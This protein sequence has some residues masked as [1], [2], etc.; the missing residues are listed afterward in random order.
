[1]LAEALGTFIL[2]LAIISVAIAAGLRRPVAGLPYSSETVA[3]AGGFA[4][5]VI[6]A[7]IGKRSG[8]HVNPAVTVA[9]AVDQ[10][11][12]WSRVPAYVIAQFAG[13]IAAAL[14]AWAVFGSKARS[15]AN[16][17]ATAPAGGASALQVFVVEAFVTFVLM[18]AVISVASGTP[19][20]T[21]VTAIAI[22]LS[23]SV[24]ILISGPISGAGVN[25]ARAL[26]PMIIAGQFTDWWAYLIAP[27]VGAVAA[28]TAH[29]RLLART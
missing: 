15:Q 28:A 17:G 26:G 21:A 19:A 27:V 6:V 16:L 13:S 8:A 12:P 7:S 24:A 2:V 29:T 3:V 4:L 22:G 10:K 9:L 18:F 11:F 25:P 23:L 1:M 20:S 14:V 5:I